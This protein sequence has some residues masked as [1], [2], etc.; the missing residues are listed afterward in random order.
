MPKRIQLKRTKG[1]RIRQAV[2][3]ARPTRWGNPARITKVDDRYQVQWAEGGTIGM[4]TKEDAASFAV[5]VFRAA[6]EADDGR[7][8]FTKDDV[9]HYLRGRDLACWCQPGSV[10]HADVLLE[11]ANA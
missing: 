9:R 2:K 4:F 10:C 7:L 11:I 3:V 5:N 1:W 8:P 6:L